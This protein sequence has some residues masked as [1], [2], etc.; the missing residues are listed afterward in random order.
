MTDDDDPDALYVN[1]E[2]SPYVNFSTRNNQPNYR[3]SNYQPEE[4]DHFY[5]NLP[6]PASRTPSTIRHEEEEDEYLPMDNFRP[7]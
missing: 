4:D 3:G 2:T 7:V 5:G 1:T 6:H